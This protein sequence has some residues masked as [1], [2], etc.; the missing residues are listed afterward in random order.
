M[1]R[2]FSTPAAVSLALLVKWELTWINILFKMFKNS[3][4]SIS[5]F[6]NKTIMF[7][8]RVFFSQNR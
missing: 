3:K 2:H 5:Y 8:D 4:K 1:S 7:L 6:K